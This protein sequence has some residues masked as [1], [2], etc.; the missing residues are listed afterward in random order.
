MS[1]TLTWQVSQSEEMRPVT[2]IDTSPWFNSRQWQIT[3]E[4]LKW[5]RD[6]IELLGYTHTHTHTPG[7]HLHSFDSCVIR[8]LPV[9]RA[10]PALALCPWILGIFFSVGSQKPTEICSWGGANVQRNMRERAQA[11]GYR[12]GRQPHGSLSTWQV[13]HS[14]RGPAQRESGLENPSL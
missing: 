10:L 8:V 4:K 11:G 2:G 3:Q 6:P 5:L 14:C 13:S 1:R 7:N 12:R 9:I